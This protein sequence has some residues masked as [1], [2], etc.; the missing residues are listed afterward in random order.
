M[1]G[2]D[3]SGCW[4]GYRRVIRGARRALNRF[5]I[6]GYLIRWVVSMSWIFLFDSHIISFLLS[7]LLFACRSSNGKSTEGSSQTLQGIVPEPT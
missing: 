1:C 7:L 4:R 2:R 3:C 6:E 5:V